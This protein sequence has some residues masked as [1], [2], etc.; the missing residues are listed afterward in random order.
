MIV[1]GVLLV[2]W[3]A[4]RGAGRLGVRSWNSWRD[5]A[6]WA[7]AVMLFFTAS[8]HFT[9]MRHDLVKMVPGWV[10]EPMS[11]I[12]M[13]GILEIAGAIGL[14]LPR[15]RRLAGLGL[16]AL[17]LALFAANVKAAREGLTLRGNPATPLW[18][19]AP[20]QLLFIWLAWWTAGSGRGRRESFSRSRTGR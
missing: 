9:P 13:T 16:C 7:L 17:F 19:R 5:S 1:L 18:L 15:T 20:M 3:I 14:L 8:A 11:V 10:P 12:Y 6:R 2:A 4:F